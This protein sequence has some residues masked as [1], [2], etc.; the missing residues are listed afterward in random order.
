MVFSYF[1]VTLL[2]YFIAYGT[3]L[4]NCSNS[5]N[6]SKHVTTVICGTAYG[7]CFGKYLPHNVLGSDST[8]TIPRCL[9][10]WEKETWHMKPVNRENIAD[11]RKT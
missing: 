8:V 9:Y 2:E 10:F 11:M 1:Y 5:S 4:D 6:N 3:A 7:C